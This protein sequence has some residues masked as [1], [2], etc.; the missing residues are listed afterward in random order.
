M[1][2]LEYVQY[3][4]GKYGDVKGDY[5]IN[6]NGTPNPKIKRTK[7][8][9]EIHHIDEFEHPLLCNSRVFRLTGNDMYYQQAN[10]L[11]YADSLEHLLLHIKIYQ[12]GYGTFGAVGIGGVYMLSSTINDYFRKGY[13][14][15][16]WHKFMQDKIKDRY[17]DYICLL[18]YF[19][20]IADKT[21]E[22]PKGANK[23]ELCKKIS[24]GWN[25]GFNKLL[26]EA[27]YNDVISLLKQVNLP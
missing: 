8:G 22:E 20:F 4:L 10:R 27:I 26:N 9:L 17:E 16:S 1:S 19:I 11:V 12:E 24:S 14:A 7:E 15:K 21:P 13:E 2:Y 3:L 23:Q 6:E 18:A 25:D 5:F